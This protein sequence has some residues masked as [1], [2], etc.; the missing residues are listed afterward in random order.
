MLPGQTFGVFPVHVVP[1]QAV[2]PAG[3]LDPAAQAGQLMLPEF[4]CAVP[5]GQGL[6]A[7][8]P[9]ALAN[10]PGE[11]AEHVPLPALEAV[12]AGQSVQFRLPLLDVVPDG[13]I[14]QA[15]LP[16]RLENR[17]AGHGRQVVWPAFG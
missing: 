1:L 8:V 13:Q 10:V 15:A 6:H 7:V 16:S 4:G 14:S 11:Q 5:A 17:P 2:L 3:A 12:P 9:G